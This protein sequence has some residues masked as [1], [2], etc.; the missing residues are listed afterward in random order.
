MPLLLPKTT[1]TNLKDMRHAISFAAR[2]TS[3]RPPPVPQTPYLL[4]FHSSFTAQVH[5][6]INSVSSDVLRQVRACVAC[7][8]SCDLR[9][10]KA[11]A[12]AVELP[13][14]SP[15]D[16]LSNHSL[17]DDDDDDVEVAPRAC[18]EASATTAAAS[19][20]PLTCRTLLVQLRMSLRLRLRPVS[21][22]QC[23][24]TMPTVLIPELLLPPVLAAHFTDKMTA[25]TGQRMKV[26]AAAEAAAAAAD[27]AAA[28]PAA[29]TQPAMQ[30]TA[31]QQL[32]QCCK[33]TPTTRW[34][35]SL[36]LLLL[37]CIAP[38]CFAWQYKVAWWF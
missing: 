12:V 36:C 7:T 31:A 37:R 23:N 28:H 3:A 10:S 5:D 14:M 16:A 34:R 22:V 8:H 9:A 29:A 26:T 21:S 11:S 1:A 18:D 27:A 2:C 25:W 30:W 15:R 20:R 24:V 32:Q 19:L 6:S 33:M 17:S 38:V 4:A 35:L 13:N